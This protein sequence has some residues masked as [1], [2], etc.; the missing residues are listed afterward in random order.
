ME[1]PKILVAFVVSIAILILSLA[2]PSQ[3]DIVYWTI[4]V[5][6]ETIQ[7]TLLNIFGP[8]QDLLGFFRIA[9]IL[10]VA[11]GIGAVMWSFVIVLFELL[12]Y[13]KNFNRW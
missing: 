8:P 7:S 5:L 2:T 6:Y 11:S 1:D 9:E 4:K 12:E 10:M 13:L 3:I